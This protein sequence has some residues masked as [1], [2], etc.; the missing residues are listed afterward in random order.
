M[1]KLTK[2]DI[3]KGVNN[4]KTQYFDKLGG[5]VDVRPLTEGEW[6]E[7]EALRSNGAK[8]KG[9]PIFNKSGNLDIKSMQ[10]NLQVEIDFE[11]IQLMEFEAKAKAVAWGLSTS[12]DTQWTVEEVKQLR[13]VGVVDDIAEFIFKISGVTEEGAEEARNFRQ[14]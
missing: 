13:P 3:L 5:E 6:A 8:I 2:A 9:R 10:Q 4:V 7:I 11:G 14:E 12:P 1:A